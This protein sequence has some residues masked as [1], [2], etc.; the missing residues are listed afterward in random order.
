MLVKSVVGLSGKHLGLVFTSIA[1]L[2]ICLSMPGALFAA[3][4]EDSSV[5]KKVD[6]FELKDI[7][8]T[9]HKLSD[10]SDSSVVV[11][12]F[13]GTECPLA[14]LYAPVLV[15]MA[16]TYRD[17]EVK[18]L[19][20]NSNAQDSLR[21]LVANVKR[22]N[23]PFPV[24]R[25]IGNKVADQIGATRTPEVFVLDRDR[26]IQYQGRIDDQRF[27]GGAR[28][29]KGTSFLGDAVKAVAKGK[30]PQ[31]AYEPA[32]GCLIGKL[33]DPSA[34]SEVTFANQ[35]SR[36][37]NKRCVE[38][39]REG[40]IGPFVLD[41]YDEVVGW[42][43][44]IA[45][46]IEEERMPPWHAA[47]EHGSFSNNRRM[48]DE[49]KKT[50]YTWVENGAPLGDVDDMPEPPQFVEGWQL[51][52]EPDLVI[53]ITNEPVK[54]PA[55]NYVDYQYFEYETKFEEDKWIKEA[56]LLPSNRAIVHH[57]LVFVQPPGENL[58]SIAGGAKGFLVG[59]VPGTRSAPYPD[60]MA[61]RIPAGS[62][63]VFQMHYTP[64]GT[65][66]EDLSRLA[67]VFA[68]PDSVKQEVITTSSVAYTLDIPP[69]AANH[70]VTAH[71]HLR[72]DSEFKLLAL[73]PHM[74]LRGK[75]FRYELI[76]PDQ[77]TEVLL[78][79]PAYDF[80]WQTAY[81]LNEPM[82][83]ADGVRMRCVAHFDNSS[84]NPFNPA[85]SKQIGWGEQTDDEMMIGYFDVAV[86]ITK[87]K[88]IH[89]RRQALTR[90]PAKLAAND[91]LVQHDADAD[92]ELS[93]AEL[94]EDRRQVFARA[95]ANGDSK[96]SLE[97]LTRLIG[98]RRRR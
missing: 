26:V 52:K 33:R 10:Y 81:M 65:P 58:D 85:P 88:E 72:L 3:D 60:G 93:F 90:D 83:L 95:D 44:M 89:E 86:P 53:P 78:D 18:F 16:E 46:V 54:I 27:V 68:E 50:I 63:L 70:E 91:F 1:A 5:G 23:I 84:G 45:E 57:I 21:D 15:E 28:P 19:M 79:V 42:A 74:H 75:A 69:H 9:P 4:S 6:D 61:K 13:S 31:V 36:I 38:C 24:L 73:M 25:D 8:G 32:V 62:K 66:Q 82:Q 43:E 71:S 67:L 35:V 37:L 98:S 17:Q 2:A 59:Y 77:T 12:V 64:I 40:E 76:Y 96:L 30:T 7:N 48:S 22:D 14:K 49:E 20:V 87:G 51:T 56:E 47:P 80:N 94:P 29:V 92:E 39:H 41:D 97:E 11:L 55:A 34:D